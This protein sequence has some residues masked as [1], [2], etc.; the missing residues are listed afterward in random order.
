MLFTYQDFSDGTLGLAWVAQASIAAAGGIC[1]PRVI[2]E[3]SSEEASFNTA[4]VSLLNYGAK[5]PRKM[6]S[7][8]VLHEFGHSFGAKVN[9]CYSVKK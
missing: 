8:T 2:L 4:V 3:S 1:S 9:Y 5:V 6:A 7:L